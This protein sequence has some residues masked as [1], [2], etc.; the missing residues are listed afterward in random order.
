M[1]VMLKDL[2]K[3]DKFVFNSI[4]YT[5][6]QRYSEWKKNDDPYL[7]TTDGQ[8]WYNEELEVEKVI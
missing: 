8:L 3:N 2:K 7:K 1:N 4:T 5:V 6:S